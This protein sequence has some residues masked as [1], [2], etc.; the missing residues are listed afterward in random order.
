MPTSV[1][2]LWISLEWRSSSNWQALTIIVEKLQR[3]LREIG[4]HMYMGKLCEVMLYNILIYLQHPSQRSKSMWPGPK[5]RWQGWKSRLPG[6]YMH[7]T[8]DW[9]DP[10]L[11]GSWRWK[12]TELWTEIMPIRWLDQQVHGF[13]FKS[14]KP[15]RK[16][17]YVHA[18]S[19]LHFFG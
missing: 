17:T 16:S 7:A 10:W 6:M 12:N 3:E 4:K 13:T 1:L 9:C 14:L 11:G 15:A 19:M 5:S 2:S 18:H 8:W